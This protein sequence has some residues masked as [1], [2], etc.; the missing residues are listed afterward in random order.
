M[1]VLLHNGKKVISITD[2][3]SWKPVS[4][5]SET[6]SAVLYELAGKFKNRTLVWVDQDVVEKADFDFIRIHKAPNTLLSYAVENNY[7]LHEHFGLIDQSVFFKINRAVCFSTYLMS[8]DLGCIHS[9][10][11]GHF[12]NTIPA[13]SDFNLFLTVLAKSGMP[14]GLL[15]YSQ[16]QLI[17]SDSTVK[18]VN[19]SENQKNTYSFLGATKSKVW[20]LL[21]EFQRL[22]YTK[23]LNPF[24]F[25]KSLFEKQIDTNPLKDLPNVNSGLKTISGNPSID[26]VIPTMGRKKVLHQTLRDLAAQTV[27][28]KS[29]ILVE[30]NPDFGTSTDLDY[31]ETESWP[32]AI[33]HTFTHQTGACNA[34]NLALDEVTADWVFLAD[35]DLRIPADF[36]ENSFRFIVQNKPEAFTVSCLQNGEVERVESVIQWGA[37]GSGCSIVKHS[38]LK[39]IRFDTAFEYGFGEDADFGMQL[40][41]RGISIL[42][43]P[44][45]KLIHLKAASGGFRTQLEK[46][47]FSEETQ[48]KPAP[49]VMAFNL[50]HSTRFQI[51]GYKTLLFL[52]FYK[53]QPVRN[54]F[55]YLRQMHKRWKVSKIWA[56]K[57]LAT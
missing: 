5:K 1:I 2:R 26:V 27:L 38:V 44:F 29:V 13:Y 31:L 34:R 43:T 54:P 53:N 8:A 12:K 10:T 11:L 49:T 33:K 25:F 22:I 4:F 15:C 9:D 30:Q 55:A 36:L 52:K 17:R 41:N 3:E 32:F 24:Y 40:R 51:L 47:W 18:E 7:L 20:L 57:L 19:Y 14:K 42:Y 21:Y 56:Q 39:N 16:P 6:L 37:F 23:S 50:K 46:P 28:P 35:D 45:L 48:P